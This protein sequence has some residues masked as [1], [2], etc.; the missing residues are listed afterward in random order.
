MNNKEL[1]RIRVV[2]NKL[3]NILS[4][5]IDEINDLFLEETDEDVKT[6]L[7]LTIGCLWAQLLVKDRRTTKYEVQQ[8]RLVVDK[9]NTV[10]RKVLNN[11]QMSKGEKN[12]K[13]QRMD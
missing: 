8:L 4:R 13:D 1:V 11:I 5:A 10:V 7:H 9:L 3:T 12:E 2:L 6:Y